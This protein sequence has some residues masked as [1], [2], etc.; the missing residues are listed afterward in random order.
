MT[1]EAKGQA[2]L[3]RFMGGLKAPS[4]PPPPPP[5]PPEAPAKPAS[6][7]QVREKWA[8][9]YTKAGWYVFP[10]AGKGPLTTH[11][12][13][14]A[15]QDHLSFSWEPRCDGIG[16]ACGASGVVVVDA[17]SP[18]AEALFR[19]IV[20]PDH[21]PGAVVKTKRGHHYY[22]LDPGGLYSPRNGWRKDIDIKAGSSYVVAPSGDGKRSWLSQAF[23]RPPATLA[24]LLPKRKKGSSGAASPDDPAVI[25]LLEDGWTITGGTKDNIYLKPPGDHANE[26]GA[27]W[28][29]AVLFM[30]TTEG[31][32]ESGEGYNAAQI[33][34]MLRGKD[35]VWLKQALEEAWNKREWPAAFELLARASVLTQEEHRTG[36][37]GRKKAFDNFLSEASKALKATKK[38][39]EKQKRLLQ[40]EYP[41]LFASLGFKIRLNLCNQDIELSGD[42]YDDN[43]WHYLADAAT[44]WV[45]TQG[46]TLSLDA[47]THS[48]FTVARDNAYNPL[49]EYLE[50][51]PEWDGTERVAKMIACFHSDDAGVS[52]RMKAWMVGCIRRVY[53]PAYQNMMLVLQG[54]QDIGK[55]HFPKWLCSGLARKW[56]VAKAIAPGADSDLQQSQV[57]IWE[58][59]ELEGTLSKRDVA[60]LKAFITREYTQERAPYGRAT[61]V[62]TCIANYIG[63]TNAEKFLSD[64]TG[65]RR[66]WICPLTDIDWSYSEMDLA[67]VWAELFAIYKSGEDAWGLTTE[68]KA[69]TEVAASKA[70]DTTKIDG[71]FDRVLYLTD[72]PQDLVWLDDIVY[73]MRLDGTL[74]VHDDTFLRRLICNRMKAEGRKG[75]RLVRT[76]ARGGSGGALRKRHFPGVKIREAWLS[77]RTS[78]REIS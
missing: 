62:R 3:E 67:Q 57:W 64:A 61:M 32:F 7:A 59:E 8:G 21:V 69:D 17:D 30:H 65:N 18:E 26:K 9:K 53:E 38:G 51:L 28:N 33:Y 60:R 78:K 56:F 20:G 29:K 66:F 23:D 16:I 27:T 13:K 46:R 37:V 71:L 35:S 22:Y 58:V 77:F 36:W 68:Q 2:K 10:V 73:A 43:T 6:Q 44:D 12:H 45:E 50:G 24:F 70:L 76:A 40:K 63:T 49:K 34:E 42:R 11:G 72:N 74:T 48:M 14:D 5:P 75:K 19:E 1:E 47:L 15:S 55:S 41:A 25:I 52:A 31:P 4:T 54:D 39:E